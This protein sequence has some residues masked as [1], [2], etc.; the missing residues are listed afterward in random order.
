MEALHDEIQQGV[1]TKAEG[2]L[3]KWTFQSHLSLIGIC[4]W[5]EAH[6][7]HKAHLFVLCNNLLKYLFEF[8]QAIIYNKLI[9]EVSRVTNLCH[10]F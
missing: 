4:S 10:G 1:D 8:R 6:A 7:D 9:F 5:W 3:E 2:V